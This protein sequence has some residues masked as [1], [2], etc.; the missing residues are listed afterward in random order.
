MTGAVEMDGLSDRQPALEASA[1]PEPVFLPQSPPSFGQKN[2]QA[3]ELRDR[4]LVSYADFMTLLF[5]FFVVMYAVSSVNDE[6]Y[7][8]L[9]ATLDAVFSVP[10]SRRQ[11]DPGASAA[12]T[13]IEDGE[14][15]IIQVFDQATEV[16]AGDRYQ[17]TDPSEVEQYLDGFI[18]EQRVTVA[19][20]SEWLEISLNGSFAFEPSSARLSAEGQT[21]LRSLAP[22]LAGI[23]AAVTVEGYTDSVGPDDAP[24][25]NWALSSARAAVV[26]GG[27]QAAGVNRKRLSAVGYS[28]NHPL[29]SNATPAGRTANR[30]VSIV[31]ARQGN[32]ARNLNAQAF[33][34]TP[35]GASH[36][37]VRQDDERAPRRSPEPLRTERGGLL[38]SNEQ[39]GAANTGESQ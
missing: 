6:K 17:A 16:E 28:E 19:A 10:L 27:L 11:T 2:S 13:G 8:V 5:A 20:N 36:A 37:F 18:D 15:A 3:A 7:R 14:N 4:W 22:F 9:G 1:Q 26:A 21:V 34:E 32:T 33:Q 24:A 30:R 31:L 25:T 38:F 12:D 39:Q 35:F 29:R 23:D